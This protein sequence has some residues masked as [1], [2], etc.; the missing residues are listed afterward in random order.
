MFQNYIILTSSLDQIFVVEHTFLKIPGSDMFLLW[1]QS[2][3][4]SESIR[5]QICDW[6]LLRIRFDAK[7]KCFSQI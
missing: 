1:I 6:N 5:P 2:E 3:T 4:K 7:S